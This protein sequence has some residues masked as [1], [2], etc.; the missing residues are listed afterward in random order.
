MKSTSRLEA[1]AYAWP[2]LRPRC[3]RQL[4]RVVKTCLLYSGVEDETSELQGNLPASAVAGP[5]AARYAFA[6]PP[7]LGAL[8]EGPG[9]MFAMLGVSAPRAVHA[10]NCV[11]LLASLFPPLLATAES[12]RCS[13]SKVPRVKLL[14]SPSGRH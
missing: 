11:S 12:P 2:D 9:L 8:P 3:E 6:P 10:H 14:L 13:Y 7:V 1:D 4:D 5:L